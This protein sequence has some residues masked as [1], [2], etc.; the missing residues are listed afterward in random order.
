MFACSN[1]RGCVP[2]RPGLVKSPISSHNSIFHPVIQFLFS[3]S[4]L[5]YILHYYHYMSI[6]YIRSTIPLHDAH[7]R[8]SPTQLPAFCFCPRYLISYPCSLTF[9]LSLVFLDLFFLFWQSAFPIFPNAINTL[10]SSVPPYSLTQ[11]IHS[12]IQEET[13]ITN[14]IG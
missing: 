13:A 5:C 4:S 7:E 6:S 1:D 10:P 3:S 8:L 2:T 9:F 11:T 14:K 12:Y